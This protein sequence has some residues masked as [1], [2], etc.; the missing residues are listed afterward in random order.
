MLL[1]FCREKKIIKLL[2]HRSNHSTI[3]A[4]AA[5][6]SDHTDR[7]NSTPDTDD[8]HTSTPVSLSQE[9]TVEECLSALTITGED[10]VTASRNND[11]PSKETVSTN[12]AD[13]ASPSK[14]SILL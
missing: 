9:K 13:T 2:P 7:T 6:T 5:D 1:I 4:T 14:D 3:T 11:A 10:T 8:Q 12:E